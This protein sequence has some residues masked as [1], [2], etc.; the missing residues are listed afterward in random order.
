MQSIHSSMKQE[1]KDETKAHLLL[2]HLAEPAFWQVVDFALRN[3]PPLV[4]PVA[5]HKL[6]LF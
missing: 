1:K 4:A 6:E 3:P 2:V 5:L